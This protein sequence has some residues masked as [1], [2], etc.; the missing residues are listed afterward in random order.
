[1]PGWLLFHSHDL[2]LLVHRESACSLRPPPPL[3]I[4]PHPDF[5]TVKFPNPEEG[6]SA[7]VRLTVVDKLS[8]ITA[9][10]TPPTFQRTRG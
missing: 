1:M 2:I 10:L 5:P 3:Q 6:K 9:C 4:D 8:Q 7:L